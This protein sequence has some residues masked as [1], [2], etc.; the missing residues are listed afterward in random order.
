M[1]SLLQEMAFVD[2]IE[3]DY[4]KSASYKSY[5]DMLA[6]YI[7][8]VQGMRVLITD[9]RLAQVTSISCKD[10]C[11]YVPPGDVICS[12][13]CRYKDNFNGNN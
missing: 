3:K 6:Q 9:E 4:K 5:K 7:I 8:Y 12:Y 2:P 11:S 13:H 1:L 10:E